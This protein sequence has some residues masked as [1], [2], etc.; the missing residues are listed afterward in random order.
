[1]IAM[2]QDSFVAWAAL[3]IHADNG[4]AHRQT[5]HGHIV[6]QAIEPKWQAASFSSGLF[7]NHREKKCGDL[8]REFKDGLSGH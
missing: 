4:I 1:M 3:S 5:L 7:G 6:G 8:A 2:R